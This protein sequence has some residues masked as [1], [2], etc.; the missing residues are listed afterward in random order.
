MIHTKSGTHSED[1]FMDVN[2]YWQPV[3]DPTIGLIFLVIQLLVILAGS[4]VHYHVWKMLNREETLVSNI[5][6]AYVIVQMILWPLWS[7]VGSATYFIYPLS[8]LIGSWLCVFIYF[9]IYSGFTFIS[10]QSTIIAIMRY[11]FIV[12]DDRVGR[13][14]KQRTKQLF[15]WILGV[16]P[17][18]M[19][20]WL[21]FGAHDQNIDASP[22]F[23][24]CTGSYDKIFLLKWTFAE[25]KSTW[26]ARCGI[27]NNDEGPASLFEIIKAIQCG[28][29]VILFLLL[30]SNIFD[31]FLYYR[32]W[33]HI[34]KECVKFN[35]FLNITPY[36]IYKLLWFNTTL[37]H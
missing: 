23:N 17:I 5:L 28:A 16:V 33:T 6:K 25:R 34:I 27:A 10:F 24:K 7:S 35:L 22:T 18:I 2:L 20:T 12:H 21:Y 26:S 31:G 3:Q 30:A 11:I 14:G 8:E 32:T 19:A 36:V 1:I 29:S 9:L 13:F 4:F 15:H 37:F